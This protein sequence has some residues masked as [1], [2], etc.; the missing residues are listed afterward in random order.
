MYLIV[1]SNNLLYLYILLSVFV[2]T[3]TSMFLI[4]IPESFADGDGYSHMPGRPWNYLSVLVW[5]ADTEGTRVGVWPTPL[6]KLKL[7]LWI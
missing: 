6:Q 7:I 5:G 3:T 4:N 2:Q 1:D